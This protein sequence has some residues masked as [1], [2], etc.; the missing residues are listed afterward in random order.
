M[1]KVPNVKVF[2]FL[3]I[4]L[5]SSIIQYFLINNIQLMHFMHAIIDEK[6]IV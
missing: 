5:S 2:F 4:K 1:G 3:A 6:F